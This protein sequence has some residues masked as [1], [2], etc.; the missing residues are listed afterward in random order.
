MYVMYVCGVCVWCMYVCDV[1]MRCMYVCMYVM[2]ACIEYLSF[3]GSGET[4][5]LLHSLKNYTAE[6][7]AIVKNI[8]DN[9]IRVPCQVR[10]FSALKPILNITRVILRLN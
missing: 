10:Y 3:D 9:E 8:K 5:L 7:I 2:Y 6:L 4:Y 1:C